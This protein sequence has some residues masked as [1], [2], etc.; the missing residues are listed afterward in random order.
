MSVADAVKALETLAREKSDLREAALVQRDIMLCQYR[1]T[2][3][4]SPWR[5]AADEVRVRVARGI[6]LLPGHEAAFD[7]SH[8]E[9]VFHALLKLVERRRETKAQARILHQLVREPGVAQ[10]WL[11]TT[12][13]GDWDT[14]QGYAQR[15]DTPLLPSLL[16]WSIAPT[17]QAW[18]AAN[19]PTLDLE[20]WQMGYCPICGEWPA[21]GEW[22]GVELTR[23]LRCGLCGGDW[24][25]QRL[26]CPYCDTTDTALLGSFSA[27]GDARWRVE[28][29]G[30][31]GGYVKTETTF[32]ALPTLLL[33]VENLRSLYLDV[34]AEERGLRRPA[35]RRDV[36]Q[37]D[38]PSPILG[39]GDGG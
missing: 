27:E 13:A 37:S 5:P 16:R 19:D 26:R 39:E 34:L 21:L 30:H 31:C 20:R 1:P 4:L 7:L 28:T 23:R 11:L 10:D 14:L 18:V 24:R 8:A 9:G 25:A 15:L 22:R 29:C 2:A 36:W 6:P 33:P 17:L 38:P 12:L 35:G 32:A 3:P